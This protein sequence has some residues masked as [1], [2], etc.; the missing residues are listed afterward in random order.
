MAGSADIAGAVLAAVNAAFACFAGIVCVG[1]YTKSGGTV[2]ASGVNFLI[3]EVPP[4]DC[5]G[6]FVKAGD[7]RALVRVSEIGTA[8]QPAAGDYIACGCGSTKYTIIS[9]VLDP[10]QMFWSLFCR[11]TYT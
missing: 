1:D 10:T 6:V 4:G 9:G 11:R 8:F 5:D 3:A 7:Q 2:L